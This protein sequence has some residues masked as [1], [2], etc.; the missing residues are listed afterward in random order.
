[1]PSSSTS[2]RR[3]RAYAASASACLPARYS[4]VISEDHSPSRSGCCST[5]DSSSPTISPPGAELDPGGH[6]VLEQAQAHLLEP[7]SMRRWPSRPTSTSTSP[8]NSASPS[9]RLLQGGRRIAAARAS[10]ASAASSTTAEGVHAGRVDRQGV[11]VADADD[12]VPVAQ[13]AAQL[14]DLRLQRVA[15]RRPRSTGPR[16]ARPRARA[17]PRRGRAGPAARWS[18]PRARQAAR[19]LGGPR[20]RRAR[21][22][23][24]RH[25]PMAVGRPSARPSVAVSASSAARVTVLLC[26]TT[27]PPSSSTASS[28]ATPSPRRG[29]RPAPP[30][31][32]PRP[33]LVAAALLAADAGYLVRAAEHATVDPGAAAGRA[34][35]RPPARRRRPARRPRP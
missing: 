8:R 11:A 4:A 2:S 35:R 3:T 5:S 9:R 19:R 6:R 15:P 28:A 25:E 32:T 12:Q 16:A 10:P 30:P 20:P 14:G 17:S 29:P 18:S 7:G 23:S 22:Q 31:R 13:R 27:T 24:A 1:M 26:P 21:R 33:L 34:R